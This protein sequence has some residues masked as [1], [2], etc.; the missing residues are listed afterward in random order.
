M[1]VLTLAGAVL[2]YYGLS[3]LKYVDMDTRKIFIRFIL[4]P[5]RVGLRR[6]DITNYRSCL[7]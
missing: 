5:A 3:K 1:A 4:A 7:K 2:S 6:E